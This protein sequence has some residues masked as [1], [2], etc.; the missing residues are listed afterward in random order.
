MRL[1]EAEVPWYS[2]WSCSLFSRLAS[3]LSSVADQHIPAGQSSCIPHHW[4]TGAKWE[5]EVL[6]NHRQSCWIHP[7]SYLWKL[8][9]ME[10]LPSPLFGNGKYL[11]TQTEICQDFALKRGVI[12][13]VHNGRKKT[14]KTLSVM[15][16][17]ET[18]LDWIPPR[19]SWNW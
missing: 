2:L 13:F 17:V 7:H 16:L 1:L 6:D 4:G 19:G 3:R 9:R 10:I 15:L 11:V 5:S 12:I 8:F 18:A 14:R